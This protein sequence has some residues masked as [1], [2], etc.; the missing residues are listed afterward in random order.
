[1]LSAPS[2][3]KMG[4]SDNEHL[5]LVGSR[6]D[7]FYAIDSSGEIKFSYST[8]DK[9]ESSP[10][11]LE[12]NNNIY[13]FFGS[14]D[15]YLY[16]IDT[17][18][19]DIPGFPIFIDSAVESSPVLSDFNGD[20]IPEI[21]VNSVSNDLNIFNIDGTNYINSDNF[22]FPFSGHPIVDDV[23]LDGDLEIFIGTTNGLVGIDLKD[24]GG[25][26]ENYWHQ[27]RNSNLKTVM[28]KLIYYLIIL[29]LNILINLCCLH[30]I[31]IH[32][33]QL[34]QYLIILKKR[35]RSKFPFMI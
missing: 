7:N 31:Q 1:M 25:D 11:I 33:I 18:G 2:V 3:I 15:G 29:I 22:E 8:G 9:V 28:L 26:T 17:N 12:F 34:V 13:I 35:L 23:D 14:S 20:G 24:V 21:V 32:L 5:I 19:Q 10:I 30:L 6:D 16:G 4:E 27:Y